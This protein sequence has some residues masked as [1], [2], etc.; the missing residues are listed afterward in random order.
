MQGEIDFVDKFHNS[1]ASTY[2]YEV[3]QK[4]KDRLQTSLLILSEF[5]PLSANFTKW[6]NTLK[7]SFGNSRRIV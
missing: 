1:P 6:S 2:G 5:N 3:R 4:F 7:Q